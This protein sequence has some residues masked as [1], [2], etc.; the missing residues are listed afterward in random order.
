M[1]ISFEDYRK[2]QSDHPD[3]VIHPLSSPKDTGVSPGKRALIKKWQELER[4]PGNI[5]EYLKK[6]CNLGL[7]CGKA[8]GVDALDLDHELYKDELIE[9]VGEFETLISSHRAGRGHIL[10]Q[11]E[12]GL[13]SEKHHFIGIEYFGN[14]EE[15]AGS[16]LVLPPSIH[17]SGEVYHWNTP[18]EKAN[19]AKIPEKLKQNM[20]FLFKLEDELHGSGIS[21]P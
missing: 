2:L 11:H 6:G 3:W 4:T 21:T 9:G 1:G 16:N 15:G 18:F 8:S 7:V 10:F 14:N 20:Q 5:E 19:I 13:Y 12:E 17:Y